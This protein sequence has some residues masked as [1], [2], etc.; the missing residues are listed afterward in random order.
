[1][2]EIKDKIVSVESLALLHKHNQDTYMPMVN[3]TGEGTMTIDSVSTNSISLGS[4]T[5][6]IPTENGFEAVVFKENES[7]YVSLGDS[8]AAGHTID[9]NW[10]SEYGTG[11]QY[12]ENGNTYTTIVPRSYTDLIRTDL[13]NKYGKGNVN[14]ISFAHSGDTVAD[15]MAKLDHTVVRNAIADADFVTICI[16]ANDILQPAMSNLEEYITTGS[17]SSSEATIASNMARL[18]SDSE[19][20]S[21]VGMFNKLTSINPNAKY[22]FTTIYNPYKYLYLD[23]GR[24]GFFGPLLNTIP[25]INIDVDKYIEDTFLGGTELSYFDVTKFEWVP[26]ELDFDVDGVIK[27]SLLSTS[28]VQMLFNRINGLSSWTENYVTQL[29]TI[30][31]NKVNAYKSTSSNFM[32]AETKALF[33]TY[34]DRPES[35]DVHYND[36]VNVEFTRGYN[37]GT[38]D[39]GALWRDTNGGDVSVYWNTLVAKYLKFKYKDLG[40]TIPNINDYVEFDMEG[41]AAD[42]VEQIIMKVIVPNIDPHPEV[43]G[44]KALKTSF[45]NAIGEDYAFTEIY[46]NYRPYYKAGDTIPVNVRTSGYVTQLGTNVFFTIPLT[47]PIIGEPIVDIRSDKG[48]ILRQDGKYTHGCDGATTPATYVHPIKYSVD[49]NFNSGIVVMAEFDDTTNVI[50]NDSIGIYLDANITLLNPDEL[51]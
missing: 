4:K 43:D 37:T 47:K 42:L 41:F 15:L 11:S 17:L 39:W 49:S 2:A 25:E 51:Q 46:T 35:G 3:P 9:S 18:N 27:D 21:Y 5:K 1:M 31:R 38:M 14:A 6:F 29:N 26:I 24:N 40:N 8:I 50:N 22:V 45:I 32:V 48:F 30:I 13:M 34:P 16:G 7:T 19:L 44:H 12:G 23:T 33:D 28:A 36:L 20:M 10:E